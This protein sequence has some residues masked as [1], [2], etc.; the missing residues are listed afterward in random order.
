MQDQESFLLTDLDTYARPPT[1]AIYPVQSPYGDIHGL[2]PPP[3]DFDILVT[4]TL[5]SNLKPFDLNAEPPTP[6]R[7]EAVSSPARSK[8]P[9][10]PIT[11]SLTQ[12]PPSNPSSPESDISM[13]HDMD[14]DLSSLVGDYYA[15]WSE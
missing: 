13:E 2:T 12:S 5:N 15:F 4:E 3:E 8:S 9:P 7:T 10:S 11:N 14:L 6:P 1:D